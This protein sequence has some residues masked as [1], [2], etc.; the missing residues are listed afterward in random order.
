MSLTVGGGGAVQS[1]LHGDAESVLHD[2]GGADS[3]DLPGTALHGDRE[4]HSDRRQC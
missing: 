3:D 1:D 2:E 4:D